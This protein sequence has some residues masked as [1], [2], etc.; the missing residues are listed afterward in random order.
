M[1]KWI[2]IL[3]KLLL[4]PNESGIVFDLIFDSRFLPKMARILTYCRKVVVGSSNP[5]QEGLNETRL[6]TES[7]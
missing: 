3:C 7:I 2:E 4:V 6:A 5:V 1:I